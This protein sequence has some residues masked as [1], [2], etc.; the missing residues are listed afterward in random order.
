VVALTVRDLA[1]DEGEMD[2]PWARQNTFWISRR[3]RVVEIESASGKSTF[4]PASATTPG[5]V[6]GRQHQEAAR[7]DANRQAHAGH[8]EHWRFERNGQADPRNFPHARGDNKMCWRIA[9][10][11]WRARRSSQGEKQ[12]FLVVGAAHMVG[13]DGLVKMLESADT[14]GAGGPEEIGPMPTPR[15]QP[16]RL[17]RRSF[18]VRRAGHLHMIGAGIFADPGLIAGDLAA[19][20]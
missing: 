7:H 4:S 9:I 20:G 17:L 15:T 1:D 11:T 10:R 6:P 3:P 16:I 5:E 19:R 8:V 14:S 2:P 12:A 13:K 18:S